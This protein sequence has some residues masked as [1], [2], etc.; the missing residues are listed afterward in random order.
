MS[1]RVQAL[2]VMLLLV[3]VHAGALDQIRRNLAWT[4][5]SSND[6]IL[7]LTNEGEVGRTLTIRLLIGDSSYRYRADFEVPSGENRFLRIREILDQLMQRYPELR[8]IVTGLLQIE[9]DGEDRE[10]KSR[11]VN[12]NP[13]TGLVSEQGGESAPAPVIRS[14]EPDSGNPAGGTVVR[15]LGDHFNDSTAVKFGGV[16][17][18]RNFQSREVLV[19]VAPAHTAGVVDVEVSNG[20]RSTRLDH[21]FR[22]E[23][24][25]PVV[26]KVD[27]DQGPARGGVRILIQGR[28]FQ[29]GVALRWDGKIIES[30]YLGVEQLSTVAPPGKG[31]PISL[32]VIN[33]DGR[34]YLFPDAFKYKGLPH[35]LSISPQAGGTAGG[36]T[37]TVSGNDFESGAGI[38][39]GGHYGTTTFINSGALAAVVPQGESGYVDV[40]VSNPDGEVSTL[41]QG[42]L[43]NDPPRIRSV[44]ADPSLIV[45]QTSCTIKVDADD[46]EIGP[47]EYEYRIASGSGT[48]IGQGSHAQFNSVNVSGKVIVEVAVYDLYH[49]RATGTV[50][51][52]V[53]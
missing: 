12:L 42:F 14:V 17:A 15:I 43:Y 28:N 9:Y 6:P 7:Q 48:I 41:P 21:A 22:Y 53:Q 16:P 30:R 23:S 5:E 50:E 29:P 25:G 34:S 38:L 24:E 1:R 31:G 27:P 36:Y 19:A 44:T 3:A 11:I 40:T 26:L 8:K 51:I 2:V 39:F 32:E 37:V 45:Q 52:E 10:I 13:R 35:L 33:P 49:A 20:R 47:L 18:M 46:P 4:L